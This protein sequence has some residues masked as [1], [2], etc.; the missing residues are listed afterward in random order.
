MDVS[1]ALTFDLVFGVYL[2]VIHRIVV[3]QDCDFVSV[4]GCGHLK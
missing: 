1:L 2:Q 3:V 4:S